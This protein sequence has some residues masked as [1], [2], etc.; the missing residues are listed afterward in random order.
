MSSQAPHWE[1]SLFASS[2]QPKCTR[3]SFLEVGSFGALA[4][5]LGAPVVSAAASASPLSST[6]KPP[7]AGILIFNVGGPSH[8]DTFDVKPDAPVEIRGPFRPIA[9]RVP[10]VQ[11]SEL[12]PRHAEIADKF[13]LVRSCFHT[14][15]A[16]H[17]AGWQL[18]QTGRFFAAGLETPH[19]GAVAGCLNRTTSDM[20]YHVVLPDL[21]GRG[22]GNLAQAQSAGFLGEAF[23]P[24][25][26]RD[27]GLSPQPDSVRKAFDVASEPAAVRDR[28]GRHPFG[29]SCLL[30]RRLV[31]HGVG[32][33]TINTF[34]T[35]FSSV[36]WDT[37]G[38]SPFSN[39]SDLQ[40]RIAPMYDQ[41]YAALIQDL[42]QRGLLPTT[43][44]CNLCE[45]GRTPRINPHGGR[46]HWPQCFTVYFA[47]G[48][49]R[50]G[51]VIGRSDAIG[52]SP[53]ECPVGP[54]GIVASIFQGLGLDTSA[55]LVGPEGTPYPMVDNA[56]PI[57]GLFG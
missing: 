7:R 53:E 55:H 5:G 9:T 13:T 11:I 50:G 29:R 24:F 40:H 4:C 49:V 33:V 31:E 21:M 44:V 16:V 6:G 12:F 18:M 25:T 1:P 48:G 20:P 14:G 8:V 37:H 54:S 2:R 26:L 17:D 36:S 30:A 22:G 10:G 42:D 35:V 28:Y 34:Q 3:R 41:G 27:A 43:L 47:G 23:R 15:P 45:F 57:P 32:F 51:Q 39:F 52:G 46:D 19:V 38:R 56:V